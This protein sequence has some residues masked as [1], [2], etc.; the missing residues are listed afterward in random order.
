[1]N[2]KVNPNKKISRTYE[3]G[4]SQVE[5]VE[6]LRD[7]DVH[8]QNVRHVFPLDVAQDVDEPLEVAVGRA[9]PQ[10][11]DLLASDAG[12]SAISLGQVRLI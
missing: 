11:V 5:L 2:T 6:E 7:E 4:R 1:M 10:E 3:H 8:L 12:I 9:D